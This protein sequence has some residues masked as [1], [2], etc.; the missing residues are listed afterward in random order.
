M[1]DLCFSCLLTDIDECK[2]NPCRNG[3][4]CANEIGGYS[5]KCM[6]GYTGQTC[7]NGMSEY[8]VTF[9]VDVGIPFPKWCKETSFTRVIWVNALTLAI[10]PHSIGTPLKWYCMYCLTIIVKTFQTYRFAHRKS[11]SFMSSCVMCQ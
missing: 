4:T 6:E 3:A 8:H 10:W 1:Y 9:K 2:S 7:D 11:F 5:C